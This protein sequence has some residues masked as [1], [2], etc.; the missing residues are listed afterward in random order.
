L[1]AN[2][3]PDYPAGLDHRQATAGLHAKRFNGGS[4]V[5]AFR[6]R[7]VCQGKPGGRASPVITTMGG[8]PA[9]ATSDRISPQRRV[10]RSTNAHASIK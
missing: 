5:H 3:Y 1:A 2:G 8:V 10:Q 4:T 7:E 6:H 9:G